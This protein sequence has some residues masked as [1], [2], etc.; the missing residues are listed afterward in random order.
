[1]SQRRVQGS[2]RRRPV[3]LVFGESINDTKA[4]AE[5]LLALCPAL[6]GMVKALP[7]PPILIKDARMEDVRDRAGTI[8]ALIDAEQTTRDVICVFAH[9]DCDDAEPA[10]E[11]IASKIEAAMRERGHSVHAIVP[12]WNLEAWWLLWPDAVARY[13]PTWRRLMTRPGQRVGL[14]VDSKSHLQRALRPGGGTRT[15]DYRESDSQGIAAA[16]RELGIVRQPV[17]ASLSFTRFT[18]AADGCC[19]AAT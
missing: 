18:E 11:A 6:D 3:V 8:A 7:R 9:E 13:R 5:L 14:I 19:V 4:I 12:A 16:V 15:R 17:G 1:M 2:P 10:H